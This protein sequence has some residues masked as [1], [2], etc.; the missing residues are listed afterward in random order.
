MIFKRLR[1]AF[2][3]L[4]IVSIA[5]VNAQNLNVLEKGGTQTSLSIHN[6]RSMVFQSDNLNINLRVGPPVSFMLSNLR[7]LTFSPLTAID[8]PIVESASTLRIFPNPAQDYL[9]INLNADDNHSL[10]AKIFTIDGRVVLSQR[11]NNNDE[12]HTLNVSSL[13]KG[14]YYIVLTNSKQLQSAKF[15]KN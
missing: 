12:L 1:T 11:L 2:F 15:F 4:V 6:I 14:L 3:T 8:D 9:N 5:S 13:E 7:N 10:E